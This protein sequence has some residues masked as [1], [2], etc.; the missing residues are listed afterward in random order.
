MI[1]V[2]TDIVR[3]RR[4]GNTEKDSEDMIWNLMTSIYKDGTPIP[5]HE[6]AGI[7]IALLM[8]GQHSSS[9][10]S[11]WALL[12]LAQNPKLQQE[13]YQEQVDVFGKDM[14]PLQY[15][16]M[17]K[18]P[19][20]AQIIKETLRM[21]SPIHSILRAVTLPMP[22][23]GTNFVIPTSHQ[24]LAAPV[25]SSMSDDYFPSPEKWEPHRWDAGALGTNVA[26][27]TDEKIDYGYGLVTKG[28]SSPYLPF[29][30]GRHRCI[31]EQFATLQMQ[32]ILAT[33]VRE[34]KFS[35]DPK[36]AF[37]KTDYTVSLLTSR[38]L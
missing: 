27:E 25:A 1:D 24:L 36:A 38:L 32:S 19:I 14:R 6:I 21:H 28:A 12:H 35:L 31:G 20:H 13:L 4:A 23:E 11:S 3:K 2:Y 8:G 33:L 9:S 30:A 17:V 15:E 22:V 7:M 37:P 10:T 5:D 26:T 34:F 16:D 18:L 29:G